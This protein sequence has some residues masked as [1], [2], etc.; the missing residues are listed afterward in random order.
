M[1]YVKKWLNLF[2]D[3]I[4][5]NYFSSEKSEWTLSYLLSNTSKTMD[6]N[7]EK[8]YIFFPILIEPIT[9]L[10]LYITR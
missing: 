9:S 6:K 8:N 4:I 10:V 3:I 7:G 2:G 1:R 5:K